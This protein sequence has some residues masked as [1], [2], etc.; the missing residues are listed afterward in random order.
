M[1][2]SLTLACLLAAGACAG[3][4]HPVDFTPTIKQPAG[5]GAVFTHKE[6]GTPGAY[7]C[8]DDGLNE[9]VTSGGE[10]LTQWTTCADQATGAQ[11]PAPDRVVVA[12]RTANDVAPPVDAGLVQCA[13]VSE[14]DVMRSPFVREGAIASVAAHRRGNAVAGAR[15][16]LEPIAGQTAASVRQVLTCRRARFETAGAP[17]TDDPTL[18]ANTSIAVRERAGVVE[19]VVSSPDVATGKRILD[20]SRDLA[21]TM[22][23]R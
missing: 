5:N 10:P 22:A 23:A 9:Q 8:A 18:F 17:A 20:R 13:G 14:Q 21:A 7:K 2:N 12:E 19:V 1:R 11:P 15:V 4:N 16:V 3:P 6:G